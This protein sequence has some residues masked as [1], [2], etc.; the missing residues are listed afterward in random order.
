MDYNSYIRSDLW[1]ERRKEAL[2][3]DGLR[4][5]ICNSAKDLEVHHRRYPK[6]LLDDN[7]GNL[8]T[9][10]HPCHLWFE[11][12]KKEVK[13]NWEIY[14]SQSFRV[15]NTKKA[16]QAFKRNQYKTAKSKVRKVPITLEIR[17]KYEQN[18]K[19]TD[20]EK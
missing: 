14:R 1:R 5:R 19:K 8:T 10:C 3:R 7:L 15:A 20:K 2:N 4:C 16:H 17:T 9:L 6:D 13:P 12:R 18:F 11:F